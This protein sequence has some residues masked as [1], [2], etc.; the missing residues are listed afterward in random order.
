MEE[1]LLARDV[2]RGGGYYDGGAHDDC[3]EPGV[4]ASPALL[5]SYDDAVAARGERV[6]LA[7]LDARGELE[8]RVVLL[9]DVDADGYVER[10]W[11]NFVGR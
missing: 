3:A 9:L 4:D 10:R 7:E 1:P 6:P 8:L 2:A 11:V 5:D